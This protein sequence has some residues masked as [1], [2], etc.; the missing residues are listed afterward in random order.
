MNLE[1]INLNKLSLLVGV[2]S[3]IVVVQA[4]LISES[5]MKDRVRSNVVEEPKVF[6]EEAEDVAMDEFLEV[7]AK[8][9]SSKVA[10]LE[11]IESEVVDLNGNRVVDVILN[12]S[13][14]VKSVDLS[15]NYSG[16]KAEVVD[17]DL[18]SEGTQIG[19]GEAELYL[20]NNV[21]DGMISISAFFEEGFEGQM[22][23]GKIVL[24][25]DE[26]VNFSWN[27]NGGVFGGSSVVDM[28][29]ANILIEPTNFELKK[30]I[31]N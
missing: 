8:R 19:Y 4:V 25:S 30:L 2:L 10:R 16:V 1:K 26:M 17:Q 5:L 31:N 28:N 20:K 12:S 18:E 6:V 14:K 22:V 24:D 23:L 15:L 9:D 27:Y 13:T 21:A 11:L 29:G 3:L 7:N